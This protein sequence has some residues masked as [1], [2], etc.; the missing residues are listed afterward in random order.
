MLPTETKTQRRRPQQT[1]AIASVEYVCIR[2][3]LHLF[4]RCP[5]RPCLMLAL[6]G[7]SRSRA[8]RSVRVRQHARQQRAHASSSSRGVGGGGGGG[9]FVGASRRC[10]ASE[11]VSPRTTRDTCARDVCAH[12]TTVLFT[13]RFSLATHNKTHARTHAPRTHALLLNNFKQHT[14]DDGKNPLLV[15]ARIAAT[16][17]PPVAGVAL[18]PR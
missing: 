2:L 9:F 13:M 16:P 8:T 11:H 12:T 3:K 10:A 15:Y 1:N 18:A 7:G 17:S 6:R 4:F 5:A 14:L